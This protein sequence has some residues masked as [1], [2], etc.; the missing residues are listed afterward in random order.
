LSE[1]QSIKDGVRSND[2]A[3][4]KMLAKEQMQKEKNHQLCITSLQ[5]QPQLSSRRTEKHRQRILTLQNLD[6]DQQQ[7]LNVKIYLIL[8]KE[9][10]ERQLKLREE[11]NRLE[12]LTQKTDLIKKI[13]MNYK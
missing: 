7:E 5:R 13:Q 11:R 10:Y 2:E 9:D 3:Y 1:L 4:K 6:I 12:L 8:A